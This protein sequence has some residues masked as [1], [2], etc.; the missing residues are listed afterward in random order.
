MPIILIKKGIS[1]ETELAGSKGRYAQYL[2]QGDLYKR[3]IIRY[4]AVRE[5]NKN[6][7]TILR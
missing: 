7:V 5:E 3:G 4:G 2:S 6:L 1:G